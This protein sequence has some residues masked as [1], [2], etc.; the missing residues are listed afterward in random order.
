[1]KNTG[2]MRLLLIVPILLLPAMLYASTSGVLN[3][4]EK[5]LVENGEIIVR[6]LTTD[7]KPGR[8]YEAI[9]FINASKKTIVQVLTA[10][11]QYP[12]C[13]PNVSR[14]D[15]VEQCSD[16]VVLNYTLSLPLGKIKKYRL[17]LSTANKDEK[18]S[19]LEWQLQE[20][21]GLDSSE[22]I[23]DTTGYWLVEEQTPRRSRVLYHVYTDPGPIPFGLGWIVDE[24][25]KNSVP[26][27]LLRTRARAEK[28]QR[29]K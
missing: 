24:L 21:P 12:E 7:D 6:E 13:M 14:I 22:T 8:T 19:R 18:T 16:G 1:M 20:W 10:Y 17:K 27:A 9:G 28:E 23:E 5:V 11:E 29:L 4:G 25:S 2:S 26:E 15:V 3:A